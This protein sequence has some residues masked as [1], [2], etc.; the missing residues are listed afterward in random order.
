MSIEKSDYYVYG[1]VNP[2]KSSKESYIGGDSL[3][4][5]EYFYFGYS[6]DEKR[7]DQHLKG[8]KSD[9]NYHKK[10][11]I[12]K[13]E[14]NGKK[15]ILK[16]IIENVDKQT[17][18]NK[19]IEMIAY[20]GR[21]D[22]GLGPLTNM[23]DGGDGGNTSNKRIDLTGKKFGRLLVLEF[24]ER[25]K[26]RKLKWLCRCDC[27][28]EKIIDGSH[29]KSG[30][31]KSCG[32]QQRENIKKAC[33]KHNKSNSKIFHTWWY[34]FKTYNEKNKVCDRWTTFK[35]F[36]ED[37]GDRPSDNHRLKRLDGNGNFEPS[38]CKWILKKKLQI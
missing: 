6:G 21:C 13:I 10:N 5:Y 20:Y 9:K 25:T 32:C 7:L 34:I 2:L 31:I 38:N 33:T 28:T 19:E 24:K 30:K 35:N 4:E 15:V 17:A 8:K 26:H 1:L 23:T 18:K 16:K 14:R 29:M 36:Y 37:M 12:K 22:L 27:G 11:T 3:Y